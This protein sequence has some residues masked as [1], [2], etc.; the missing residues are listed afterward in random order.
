MDL[1]KLLQHAALIEPAETAIHGVD[2]TAAVRQS[3][4]ITAAAQPK[5]TKAS[6]AQT[7]GLARRLY[8]GPRR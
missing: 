6:T 4:Q 8:S 3:I 7:P 5:D 1:V 2:Q